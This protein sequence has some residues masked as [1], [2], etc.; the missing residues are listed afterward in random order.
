MY[1]ADPDAMFLSCAPFSR[2][3]PSCA[4][5][6]EMSSCDRF[7]Q[8]SGSSLFSSKSPDCIEGIRREARKGRVEGVVLV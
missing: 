6:W 7:D 1:R 5:T 3:L 4:P 8:Y 2:L